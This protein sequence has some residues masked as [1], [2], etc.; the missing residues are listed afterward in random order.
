MTHP[1]MFDDAD[2]VLG[3]LR[4]LALSL[5]EAAEKISHGRPAFFTVRTFAS[6][7]GSPRG[8]THDRHDTALLFRPD[9]QDAPALRQDPRFWEPA[10]LWPHGWLALDLGDDTDWAEVAELLDASYRMTAPRR[11]VIGLDGAR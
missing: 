10:Y 3:R 2:P 1:V 4:A 7:G 6:Y 11:L 8:A 5:P 9:D